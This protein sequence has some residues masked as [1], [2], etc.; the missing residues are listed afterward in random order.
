MVQ[1]RAR[2]NCTLYFENESHSYDHSYIHLFPSLNISFGLVCFCVCVS[3][4][5]RETTASHNLAI[6]RSGY[7][8]TH[9]HTNKHTHTHAHILNNT[10]TQYISTTDSKTFKT[11]R[12]PFEKERLDAELRLCGEY[13]LR[14]KREIWRAQLALAKLRKTARQLLTLPEDHPKRVFEGNALLRRLERYGLLDEDEKRLDFVLNLST[15]KLLDRRLQ[16][17][18]L[19]KGLARSIHMA[20]VMIRQRHITVGRQLVTVPSFLVRSSSERHI[21]LSSASPYN[22]GNRPGRVGRK[23]QKNKGGD[24]GAESD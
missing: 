20:R 21:S 8:T 17:L 11:P 19:K 22:E 1:T 5:L 7:T 13:G 10:L 12:R 2:R 16:T 6:R 3:L 14:C 15:Q 23:K 24:D 9:S 4:R 18:V